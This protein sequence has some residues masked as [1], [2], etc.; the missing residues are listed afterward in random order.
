MK[1]NTKLTEQSHDQIVNINP[2]INELNHYF[3]LDKSRD[4]LY[5]EA[6]GEEVDVSQTQI[7]NKEN[8]QKLTN[9]KCEDYNYFKLRME[10]YHP[11]IKSNPNLLDNLIFI[12]CFL[13]KKY[14]EFKKTSAKKY[15]KVD[16]QMKERI[17]Q[18]QQ[19]SNLIDIAIKLS[20]CLN[21]TDQGAHALL[22]IHYKSEI[23]EI[24]SPLFIK[25][26]LDK[27]I[28]FP[29]S[30]NIAKEIELYEDYLTFDLNEK[31]P[32]ISNRHITNVALM[33]ISY[34]R[35]KLDD[36][37]DDDD[38]EASLQ[39]LKIIGFILSEIGF[40]DMEYHVKKLKDVDEKYHIR[41][42]GTTYKK[43]CKKI[44]NGEYSKNHI[45]V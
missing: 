25:E 28:E 33:L 32:Q 8:I 34:I 22:K 30:I 43:R 10:I 12:T 17:E 9:L 6:S 15:A 26:I 42:L 41:K 16:H 38:R 11:Q 44:F 27:F 40:F 2:D 13:K 5:W 29:P 4:P 18:L 37:D 35:L 1:E 21:D 14:P 39:E 31:I 20:T 19:Y 3:D 45:S 23:V 24:K 36:G 7:L